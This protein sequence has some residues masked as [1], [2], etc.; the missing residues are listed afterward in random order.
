MPTLGVAEF[1]RI[2]VTTGKPKQSRVR[3]I[4]TRKEYNPAHDYYGPLRNSIKHLFTGGRHI[5]HLYTICNRQSGTKKIKYESIVNLFKDWQS[6]K[7][8]TA[9]TPP[10]ELYDFS[11]TSIT[12]N[13]ELHVNLNGQARLVKLHFNSTDKMTQERA[14]IICTVMKEAINDDGFEHSVLDLSTGRELFFNGDYE[15]TYDRINREIKL[16]EGFW[17]EADK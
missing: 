5:S 14:N 4:S 10:R 6:G 13:P 11:Q 9:F 12:C 3:N 16:L 2:V 8:I 1:S 17:V 7:A 15:K